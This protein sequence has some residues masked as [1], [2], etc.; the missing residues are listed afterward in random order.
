MSVNGSIPPSAK[1]AFIFLLMFILIKFRVH[2]QYFPK[3]F[4]LKSVVSCLVD[5]ARD[6]TILHSVNVFLF[7]SCKFLF[8]SVHLR[9]YFF[10][11]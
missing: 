3:T 5:G 7:L 4:S 1:G 11:V 2:F 6:L 10:T 9:R 8:F